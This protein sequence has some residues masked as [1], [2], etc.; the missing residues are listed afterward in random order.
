M[1]NG[2]TLVFIPTYNERE[3]IERICSEIIKV[4]PDWDL[5]FLDDNSPDGTGVIIDDLS[6]RY[7]NVRAMHR[8]RKMGIGS[9]HMDG[10][11]WAYANGY[12]NLVTMDCDF[13]HSPELIPVFIENGKNCDIV[14]GSRYIIKNSLTGWNF[15]RRFLTKA[16]H[17]L[18]K[19][20][21]GIAYDATG[22]FRLYRLDKIPGHVFDFIQSKGYSFFFESLYILNMNSFS[23]KEVPII[24]SPRTYGHSKMSCKDA[25]H[26]FTQLVRI[27]FGVSL[28]RKQYEIPHD[29]HIYGKPGLKDDAGSWDGYWKDKHGKTGS[30]YDKVASFY[31]K[32]VIQPTLDYF[33]KKYFSEGSRLL[34]AGCGSGQAD[35]GIVKEFSIVALDQS[36]PALDMYKRLNKNNAEVVRGD[37]LNIPFNNDDFDGIY[38]IG[39]LEHFVEGQIEKILLEFHRVLKSNGKVVTFW[40]PVFGMSVILLKALHSFIRKAAGKDVRLHPDEPTLA[41]SKDHVSAVFEKANFKIVEC[42][43]GPRDFFT[44]MIIVAE[45]KSDAH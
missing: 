1:N 13:T 23:I 10:I 31:R 22:A 27:Y 30:L 29:E 12:K 6:K 9:A 11:K 35:T 25:F 19:Y 5:L 26:S 38:N 43:F 34:H 44:H 15:V 4:C 42:Y 20:C 7:Q 16:G 2:R 32:S 21:L 18:T 37:I 39:V 33:I 40:P 8:P 17:F 45:K 28:N 14:V 3:N 36:M 24:L 41:K